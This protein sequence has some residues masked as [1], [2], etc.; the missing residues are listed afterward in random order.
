[1]D[2]RLKVVLWKSFLIRKRHWFL[3]IC[4]AVLPV[5][6]FFMIAYGRSKISGL[7]K[8]EVTDVTHNYKEPLNY[9]ASGMNLGE[10]HIYYSPSDS[11][12]GDIVH[13]VQ[14]KFSI[15]NNQV[16]GF[17]DK[18]SL[19]RAYSIE[20]N[21]ETLIAIIFN[22]PKNSTKLDYTLRYHEQSL[23]WETE[24][25]YK[26]PFNFVPGVGSG[27][28]HKG[29]LALQ[30]AIDFSF[31]EKMGHSNTENILIEM[32]EFPY[33]PHK[34][35]V[36]F[37][38]LFFNYL[39]LITMFSF[40]FICPA[41]LKRVVEEK[42]SGI[43]ELMKM[44]GMRSWML[45][46]GWFIYSIVP[47]LI[48][49]LLITFFLKV[50]LFGSAE[51]VI[52]HTACSIIVFYLV[53]Y[54][55][56]I[57]ALS[58]FLSTLFNK[59]S[60]AVLV[61]LLVWILSFFVPTYI[62]DAT[63]KRESFST[64]MLLMLLPNMA[65]HYGYSAMALYEEREIGLHWNNWH[66]PAD[67]GSNSATMLH[68]CLMLVVDVFLYMI[69]T[70]YVD[71]VNPG[72]YGIRRSYL[73]PFDSL[74]KLLKKR[75]STE[76]GSNESHRLEVLEKGENLDKG[77]ELI[78]LSKKY[79]KKTVVNNLSL[80][81]YK[82]QITVLL[83]HNGA[84]KS[85]TMG[86]ITGMISKNSGKIIINGKE[87]R[88]RSDIT[89]K[90]GLC[91]QHN[92][93]FPDLTVGEHLKFFAMLKGKTCQEADK[94]VKEKLEKLSLTNKENSLADKLS[95][96]MKRKLCLG[97]AV[98][99]GSEILIL[100][101]PSSGMDP[102][103]RRYLWDLLLD[104]ASEKTI[105]ITTHFMDEADALG[106]WIAIMEEGR[107]RCFGT[108]MV[109]KKRYG[110]GYN[111]RLLIKQDKIMKANGII[112]LEMK[113]KE[114]NEIEMK[115]SEKKKIIMEQIVTYLENVIKSNLMPNETEHF[116]CKSIDGEEVSFLL[117]FTNNYIKLFE[118]LEDRKE[119]L[120]IE[121]MSI[122][123][124]TLEDVFLNSN[125]VEKHE[126]SDVPSIDIFKHNKSEYP[127]V[128]P[129]GALLF[130]RGKFIIKK[131]FTYI[132][133]FIIAVI[134]LCLCIWLGQGWNI[135][136]TSGGPSLKLNLTSYGPTTVYFNS[137]NEPDIL[138]MKK[139]YRHLVD[140]EQSTFV[141][142]KDVS[143]AIITEGIQNLPFYRLHMV[144]AAE[145]KQ[146]NKD[147]EAVALYNNLAKHSAPISL[148]LITNT[149]AKSFL[150]EDYSI[151]LTNHPLDSI[152]ENRRQKLSEVQIG[153]LWLVIMPIGF[154]FLLGSFIYF[155][156]TEL[157]TNF[158]QLQF[159]RVAPWV[160]W[161]TLY[162]SDYLMFM[163]FGIL[164]ASFTMAW[165]PFQGFS[166]F[167][168]MLEILLLYGSSGLP[169]CYLFSR[170]KSF[171]G[172]YALYIIQGIILGVIPCI[173][174]MAL[175]ESG[176]SYYKDIGQS[177]EKLF[178]FL[179]P[180]F[181]FTYLGVNFS[182]QVIENYNFG[183][184]L[185]IE[186]LSWCNGQRY[187][188]CCEA[189]DSS[190]CAAHQSFSPFIRARCSFVIFGAVFYLVINVLLH[191]YRARRAFN[192]LMNLY[193]AVPFLNKGSKSDSTNNESE[194]DSVQIDSNTKD[195]YMTVKNLKKKFGGRY[196]VDAVNFTLDKGECMG[197][198]GVNGA[199]KTT[200]FRILTGD[201]IQD[202]G[203]IHTGH[204]EYFK[205][206]GYCPQ[207]DALNY[208]LT[209]REILKTMAML[210]GI[211][212]NEFVQKYLE[213]FELDK[214]ADTPCGFYSGGNK[215]KLSFAV[216][217]IGIPDIILL[218]EPTNG[219]DAATRRKFWTLIKRIK[220]RKDVAFILTSHSMDECEALCNNVNIMKNGTIKRH[221]TI[222][223]LKQEIGGFSIKLKLK[224][225]A[226]SDVE[227]L[228]KDDTSEGGD[229]VDGV[230]QP[231]L[232]TVTDVNS[233]KEYLNSK[234]G[235]EVKSQQPGLLHY[236]IKNK[237]SKKLS[238]LFKEFYEIQQDKPE[239]IEDYYIT[240]ASL[241]DVFMDVASNQD[242]KA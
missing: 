35:D 154:L 237:S 108:P 135:N 194:I 64:T 71:A 151:S 66:L 13:S 25:L 9:Y 220:E 200:T 124:T 73:F 188:P 87:V 48:S 57:T 4:E 125:K 33:P 166:Q 198:L 3:L 134:F 164:I 19:L 22:S 180:Q 6:L 101:E 235:G 131:W 114:S 39:P 165:E 156:Y 27:Y 104:M 223:K 177:L 77:I 56:A 161:I 241:E 8:V 127:K 121:S 226:A 126:K 222:S 225:A 75:T 136:S 96:G 236:Y 92:L 206:M 28:Q 199:G 240:D 153:L 181:T 89:K 205:N 31:I 228:S 148:N 138:K 2:P 175:L 176:D 160:Y 85:T 231:S 120:E 219:V 218:D 67:G 146:N 34:S 129:L 141:D 45:W 117:P 79:G 192:S 47:M 20:G 197:F 95:G 43:K 82:N 15:I 210:R 103:S 38:S 169:H 1:M 12:F 216:A 152:G 30:M 184:M 221:G 14:E 212:D 202:K 233:L 128:L 46:L 122:T 140:A 238:T 65:L 42:Y 58:F 242:S 214:I 168:W 23:T 193:Y 213:C 16:R 203:K 227:T 86:M 119:Q 179:F 155:P 224:T 207:N 191:S 49:V 80:D 21:N 113:G 162:S 29:F 68:V 159:M 90:I 32:L 230:Y 53:L 201:E 115:K 147:I 229:E 7:N 99:G 105:L 139:F 183:Q 40:I 98:I 143:E 196:V 72:K 97:M 26:K 145:V 5:L 182:K 18:E 170:R 211:N 54:I 239:L 50:P 106:N 88:S 59:P 173:T 215:R 123:V 109:L 190:S 41:V 204:N 24:K 149:L 100:D 111:L 171:S 36:G 102:E 118:Y 69:L 189:E 186:K 137:S 158:T 195:K 70:F 185:P 83:G 234:Y 163:V 37:S 209:G 76:V 61:G 116:K 187:N 74:I 11:F 81:I 172:S 142:T 60:L 93:F 91:T 208:S 55:I 133:P 150:G 10:T 84:G 63:D 78:N 178:L 174:V 132:I 217:I 232:E 130:K 110:T 52:S 167:G 107:L 62:Q 44:V 51:A 112:E 144:A 157:S 94:E 17:P